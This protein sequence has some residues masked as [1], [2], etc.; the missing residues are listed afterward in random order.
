[1]RRNKCYWSRIHYLY[2]C[3]I[4]VEYQ[5]FPGGKSIFSQIPLRLEII[6]Q[7]KKKKGNQQHKWMYIGLFVC[8][9]CQVPA[10]TIHMYSLVS[11]R[12]CEYLQYHLIYDSQFI[13]FIVQLIQQAL[14][15]CVCMHLCVCYLI[16][17]FSVGYKI[18]SFVFI[19]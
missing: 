17:L 11:S 12:R 19:V 5:L 6:L 1:M 4:F 16:C 14:P 18:Q 9:K 8:G 7:K 15:L 13:V 10:S 2:A 3:K